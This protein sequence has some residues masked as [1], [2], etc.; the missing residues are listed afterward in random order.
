MGG[1]ARRPWRGGAVRGAAGVRAGRPGARHRARRAP[2][3]RPPARRPGAARRR[4]RGPARRRLPRR[5]AAPADHR[6]QGRRHRGTQPAAG[7][8]RGGGAGDH[9]APQQGP[10]VP[11]GLRAVPVGQARL[12]QAR[13]AAAPRPGRAPGARRRRPVRSRLHRAAGDPRGGGGRGVAAAGLRRAHPGALPG[14]GAL[15]TRG[16]HPHRAAAPAAVR[17]PRARRAGAGHGP[18]PRRRRRAPPPPRPRDRLGRDDRSRACDR[19]A[20]SGLAAARS[21]VPAAGGA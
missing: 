5:V 12:R 3:H 4:H 2:A 8:R 21:D 1:G 9:G 17:R 10:G 11:G 7:V 15:G 19:S 18:G 16:Q 14:G 20:R 6:G 13:P